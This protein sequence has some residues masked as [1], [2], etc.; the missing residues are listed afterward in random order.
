MLFTISGWATRS[1]VLDPLIE[2]LPD[3][4]T[5]ETVEWWD[6]MNGGLA[7]RLEECREPVFL[8]GWS[9]G[10]QIAMETSVRCKGM[11]AGLITVSSMR[12]FKASTVSFF[13]G[14]AKGAGVCR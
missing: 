5:V 12:T 9:M 4:C 13:R 14:L 7:E 11:I 8:M 2:S 3:S 10:G 6:A 1:S